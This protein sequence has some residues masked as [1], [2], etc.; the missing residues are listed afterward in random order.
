MSAARPIRIVDWPPIVLLGL[1]ALLLALNLAALVFPPDITRGAAQPIETVT[2]EVRQ[3]E[4]RPVECTR[5]ED[6]LN[7]TTS[8]SC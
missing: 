6:H 2:R 8:L 4:G 1:C 7:H 3:I 5:I